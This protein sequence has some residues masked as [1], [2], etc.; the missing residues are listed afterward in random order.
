[1][2]SATMAAT[3]TKVCHA[4]VIGDAEGSGGGAGEF[5]LISA[6]STSLL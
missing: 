4:G 3:S 5:E 2:E 1:M 6:G